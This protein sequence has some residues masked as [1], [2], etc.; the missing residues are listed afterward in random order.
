[1]SRPATDPVDP[2]AESEPLRRVR[3][4]TG[5]LTTAALRRVDAELAW[6][7]ELPAEERSWMGLVVQAAITSFVSWYA[8]P[9]GAPTGVSDIFASAPP[10]LTRT[11][12]LQH[13]LQLVRVIVD[14][15]ETHSDHLAVPGGERDLREAVLR[16]SREVAFSAAEV[17]ARAAEVRGAWDARLEALVVDALM[18]GESDDSL[19]SRVAALGWSGHGSALVMVGTTET[20]LDDV[21]AAELRRATRRAVGDSLVGIQADRVVL[22]LGGAGDLLEAAQSLVP[23][24]GPGPVVI[25]PLVP[26]IAEAGRSA[27]AAL[28]GIAAARAWPQA[29][30]PVQADDLLPERVLIGDLSARHTLIDQAFEPLRASTGS[31][32][33]TLSAY[34]G[35][36]RSL[37]AAARSLY[38]HPN[39]VRYRLRKVAEL[40]GWDPLDARESFVLQVA[41]ALG[42]LQDGPTP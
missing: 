34:L 11:I 40:T 25:G 15:V 32:L 22:V 14:V 36:G 2:A 24:F 26:D 28:A 10:E 7:R 38:V 1:M 8:Q 16:Y 42:E 17:Y 37:E 29:P 6:H 12:S 33:E 39:T 4:G 3:E 31:V 9:T 19:R 21:K 13:T 23:R 27:T 5:L 30:R 35:T 41:L 18:R 20:K